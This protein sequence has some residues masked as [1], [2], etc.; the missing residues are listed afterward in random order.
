MTEEILEVRLFRLVNGMN[1]LT[2]CKHIPDRAVWLWVK[3]LTY[4]NDLSEDGHSQIILYP[5]LP[6]TII[7][8]KETEISE[9]HILFHVEVGEVL[10]KH[11]DE[12]GVSYYDRPKLIGVQEVKKEKVDPN[13]KE[14]VIDLFKKLDVPTTSDVSINDDSK[15]NTNNDG[16]DEGGN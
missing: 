7:R 8:A 15:S 6:P 5:F 12:F 2:R 3:P 9:V 4:V 13:S 1:V 14:A 16:D 10:N 11:V